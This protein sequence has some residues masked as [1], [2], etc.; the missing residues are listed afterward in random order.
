MSIDNY[1]QFAISTSWNSKT[2]PDLKE[3]LLEI[4][5]AGFKAIEIS[6]HFPPDKLEEI[7]RL[8]KDFD[9]KVVSTHNFCPLPPKPN[10]SRGTS[11]YYRLSSL[12]EQERNIAVEAT[13]NT[14]DWAIKLAV[15]AV[16][17]HAGMVE[18]AE[19][20]GENLIDLFNKGKVVST[21]YGDLK[22]RFLKARKNKNG[23]HIDA[24]IKSLKEILPYAA[25]NNIKLGLETRY[26]PEEIPNLEEIRYLLGIF[27]NKGLFYWHDVGHAEANDKLGITEHLAFLKEFSN[28]L[29]GIHLHDIKG[30][31]DHLAPFAGEFDF[32][33][34]TTFLSEDT[35]KVIE[36]NSRVTKEELKVALNRFEVMV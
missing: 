1:N 36:V 5:D 28:N 20:F 29:L 2:H 21:E 3:M 15:E 4:Q 17:I 10:L 16:V 13:K 34:I 11:D 24:V 27:K 35:I 22:R 30:L 7:T 23:Q 8:L 33:K 18:L 9:L 26:Y 6:H 12:N 31:E 32:S 14:I 19:P 25:E